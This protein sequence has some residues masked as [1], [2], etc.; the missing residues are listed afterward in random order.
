M[1]L[2]A[3]PNAFEAD[4]PRLSKT[5][6]PHLKRSGYSRS[7]IKVARPF[8]AEVV[9]LLFN[10]QGRRPLFHIEGELPYCWNAPG[11]W[12]RDY[13][14]YEWGHLRSRNQNTDAEHIENL[15][16]CSA[17]CNQHIQTSMDIDEVR[18]WL[19]GSQVARRIDEVLQQRTQLFQ[20]PAWQELCGRLSALG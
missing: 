12:Q 18:A 10:A 9:E 19:D 8:V 15:S 5:L 2:A 3:N 13:I 17:R 7:G 11:S 14:R 6:V 16:L 4:V 20:S 1:A